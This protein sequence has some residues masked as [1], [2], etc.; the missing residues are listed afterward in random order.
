M[1]Q[2]LQTVLAEMTLKDLASGNLAKIQ[3][4][5]EADIKAMAKAEQQT[6]KLGKAMGKLGLGK[7]AGQSQGGGGG[8]SA[9]A[10]LNNRAQSAAQAIGSGSAF[11]HAIS[12][13]HIVGPYLA[14]AITAMEGSAA[15]YVAGIRLQ[16]EQYMASSNAAVAM[17]RTITKTTNL[18]ND[19]YFHARDTQQA[20]TGL[21]D[22]G[23]KTDTIDKHKGA[24]GEFTKAQ[25]LGSLQEGVS[26]I[27]SGNIK[28]GRGLSDVQIKMIQAYAPL[29]KDTMTADIGMRNIA[30][31]LKKAEKPIAETGS[32]FEKGTEGMVKASV[33]IQNTEEATTALGT[34][35]AAAFESAHTVKRLNNDLM[36]VIGGTAGEALAD[37][38]EQLT[39]KK[40]ST[41]EKIGNFFDP[42]SGMRRAAMKKAGKKGKRAGGGNVDTAGGGGYLVGEKGPEIFQPNTSGRIIPMGN[43]R[44]GGGM[45]VINNFYV[46]GGNVAQIERAVMAAINKAAQTLWRQNSGL[47]SL[48]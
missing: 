17:K 1:S 32:A 48:G 30:R 39:D 3:K 26:A 45:S 14:A 40:T 35:S 4:A 10:A 47:P 11:H 6:S 44:G 18:L 7:A 20:L 12:Q 16:K 24:L 42:T 19:S 21:R 22:S 2:A 27:M 34:G 23:V 5:V 43:A 41:L 15:N 31:V 37:L 9:M 13:I 38:K 25:G 36:N 28:S 8:E 46:Q 33:A 29:L